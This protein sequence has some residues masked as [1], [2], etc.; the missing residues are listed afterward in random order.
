MLSR[1]LSHCPLQPPLVLCLVAQ[2]CPTLCD[3][4]DCSQPGSPVHGDC[5]GKNTGVGCH[6]LLQGIL[7]TQRLNPG[8]PHCRQIL[9]CL[10]HQGSPGI[11]EWVAYHF[12]RGYFWPRNQTRVYCIAGRFFTS[13]ATTLAQKSSVLNWL[14]LFFAVFFSK[15]FSIKPGDKSSYYLFSYMNESCFTYHFPDKFEAPCWDFVYV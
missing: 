8:L 11:L 4:I 2:S 6:A 13:W 5:P 3:P 9:N 1:K 12:S 7:P 10:S 15:Y 14:F